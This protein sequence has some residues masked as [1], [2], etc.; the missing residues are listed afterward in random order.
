VPVLEAEFARSRPYY[1]LVATP[2][3]LDRASRALSELLPVLLE[4]AQTE[5]AVRRLAAE[6]ER[7]RR[8]VNALEYIM[9]PRLQE[10]RKFIQ[11]KL[12]EDERSARVR[13]MKVKELLERASSAAQDGAAGAQGTDG[14]G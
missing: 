12:D 9:I 7:T 8:R 14:R 2:A 11:S 1:S 5:Q 6:I 4:C 13:N 3:D 10:A